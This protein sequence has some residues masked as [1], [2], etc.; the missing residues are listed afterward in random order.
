[1]SE[2]HKWLL[3]GLVSVLFGILVLGNTVIAT[4]AVTTLTG[5]ALLI[6]GVLQIIGGLSGD[7]QTGSRIFAVLM[8]ILMSFLGVNFLFNPLAGAISLTM[9]IMILLATS[10]ILRIVFAWRVREAPLFFPLLLS[11]A[12]S[13]LL[14]GYIWVNFAAATLSLLGI[15]MG[16]ELVLNGAGLIL[17]SLILRSGGRQ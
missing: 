4:L 16:I 13:V 10:G 5:A 7:R 17:W 8:G 12:L 15:L 1:M 3:L 2:A 9:L 6:A 11:G 14:A